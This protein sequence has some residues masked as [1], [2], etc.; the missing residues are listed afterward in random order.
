[1]T[2]RPL[3]ALLLGIAAAVAIGCGD[4][5][6]LLSGA[7]AAGLQ[8]ELAAVQSALDSGE[9]AQATRAANDFE[10]AAQD[11]PTS[12]DA[13]LRENLREGAAQ[14]VSEVPND[15]QR[16]QTVTTNTTTTRTETTPTT[17]TTTTPTTPTTTTSTPPVPTIPET[18]P[19]IPPD[20][21]TGDPGDG[22]GGTGDG[23]GVDTP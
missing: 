12:V 10:Q 18:L 17:T 14:L 19:E 7:D 8:D 2:V 11:L 16:Q 1:M 21:G 5:S 9:C 6:N 3:L 20:D 23:T 22:T 4:R 13:K 15:C